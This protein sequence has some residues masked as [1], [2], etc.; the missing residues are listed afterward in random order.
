MEVVIFGPFG[1][2]QFG[3]WLES[4]EP[5]VFLCWQLRMEYGNFRMSF[6]YPYSRLQHG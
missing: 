5:Q 4:F 1:N 6:S 3:F 2:F